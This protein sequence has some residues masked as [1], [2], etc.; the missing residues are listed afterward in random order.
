MSK[1][2]L[3]DILDNFKLGIMF[4]KKKSKGGVSFGEYPKYEF[5]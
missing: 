1:K 5:F 4:E 3:R 2:I